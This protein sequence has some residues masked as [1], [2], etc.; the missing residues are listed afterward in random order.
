MAP[1]LSTNIKLST[2]CYLDSFQVME[3]NNPNQN[4][5]HLPFLHHLHICVHAG[6]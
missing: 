6:V 1:Y 5:K 4:P 2:F 3:S